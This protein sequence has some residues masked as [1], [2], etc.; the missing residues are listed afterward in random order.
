MLRARKKQESSQPLEYK[1]R[2]RDVAE[3]IETLLRPWI[4]FPA[5]HKVWNDGRS[6]EGG[7]RFMVGGAEWVMGV[8][9]WEELRGWSPDRWERWGWTDCSLCFDLVLLEFIWVLYI[10]V[11]VLE[12]LWGSER[13]LA[14]RVLAYRKGPR[15]G[16]SVPVWY[17]SAGFFSEMMLYLRNNLS[18]YSSSSVFSPFP[19]PLLYILSECLKDW[20]E[21]NMTLR[22]V[23]VENPALLSLVCG[24]QLLY[25][26]EMSYV[27]LRFL[28]NVC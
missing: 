12:L 21:L 10:W 17:S 16:L 13:K 6:W 18:V 11:I 28:P 5:S 23:I 19:R 24:S 25:M 27:I 14:G 4:Q 3:L 1:V 22:M 7:G 2:T 8:W 26:T 9:C 20:N 15:N